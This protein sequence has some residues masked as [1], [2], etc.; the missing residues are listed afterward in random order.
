MRD[1][2]RGG[3]GEWGAPR[4]SQRAAA[5]AR[6]SYRWPAVGTAHPA[7]QRATLPGRV[8]V[9]LCLVAVTLLLVFLQWGPDPGGDAGLRAPARP[10]P[11]PPHSAD[12]LCALTRRCCSLA[13]W[14]STIPCPGLDHLKSGLRGG[15]G[16][17]PAG[18]RSWLSSAETPPRATPPASASPT[19]ATVT[20]S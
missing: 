6:E 4:P 20:R 7:A 12:T 17:G 13:P 8:G 19:R 10:G 14:C 9:R 3:L 1:A 16:R 2:G 15:A 11:R 5:R 18:N